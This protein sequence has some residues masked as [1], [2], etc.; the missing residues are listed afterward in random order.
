MSPFVSLARGLCVLVLAG[1]ALVPSSAPQDAPKPSGGPSLKRFAEG[2]T[3]GDLLSAW[4]EET[5]RKFVVREEGNLRQRRLTL[6]AP[7]QYAPADADFMY[8]SMLQAGGIVLSAAGPADAKLFVVDDVGQSGG[9]KAR[10]PY[11]HPQDVRNLFRSPAQ[12]FMTAFPLKY[13]KADQVRN[14]VSQI[15]TNRNVE[16]TMDIPSANALIVVGLGPT[17]TAVGNLL[18]SLDVPGAKIAE[19]PAPEKE[20]AEKK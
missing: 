13:L 9:V 19:P 6:T 1:S 12:V 17:V 14:A 4:T 8:E 5:G 18:S 11:V 7:P 3:V 20:G 15:L 16:F 2:L 10:A